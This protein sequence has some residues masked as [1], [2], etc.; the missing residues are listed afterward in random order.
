MVETLSVGVD[1]GVNTAVA[2]VCR[3][4]AGGA[5]EGAAV[6]HSFEGEGSCRA[7]RSAGTSI[8]LIVVLA[9]GAPDQTLTGYAPCGTWLTLACVLEGTFETVE[10]TLGAIPHIPG[11]TSLTTCPVHALRTVGQTGHTLVGGS[12]IGHG[13]TVTLLVGHIVHEGLDTRI[14]TVGGSRA[15]HTLLGTGLA[16]ENAGTLHK[17][18]VGHAGAG[19]VSIGHAVGCALF[20]GQSVVGRIVHTPLA[21]FSTLQT[22]ALLL[23]ETSTAL[24]HAVDHCSLSRTADALQLHVFVVIGTLLAVLSHTPAGPVKTLAHH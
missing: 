16:V 11:D 17:Q 24:A 5:G 13:G 10:L 6:A 9:L 15:S 7:L 14:A 22:H 20:T 12:L 23:V 18:L 1:L 21:A 2:V 8:Q 3:V 19:P 4:G